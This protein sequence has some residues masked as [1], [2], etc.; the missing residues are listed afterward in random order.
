MIIEKDIGEVPGVVIEDDVY[1]LAR[2]SFDDRKDRLS[3]IPTVDILVDGYHCPYCGAPEISSYHDC[4]GPGGWAYRRFACGV[5]AASRLG[6][7]LAISRQSDVC[8]MFSQN[9]ETDDVI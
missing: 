6:T 9:V 3:Y 1:L 7:L 8:R 2:S 4:W 5:M